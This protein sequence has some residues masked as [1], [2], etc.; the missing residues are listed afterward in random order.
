MRNK[1]EYQMTRIP[2][3][4]RTFENSNFDIVSD[5]VLRDSSFDVSMNTINYGVTSANY[6]WDIGLPKTHFLTAERIGR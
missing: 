5:F 1:S 6:F 3:M 2:N 4:F